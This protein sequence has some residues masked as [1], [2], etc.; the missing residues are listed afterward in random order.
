MG[1]AGGAATG[2]RTEAAAD[3]GGGKE[4]DEEEDGSADGETHAGRGSRPARTGRSGE[5]S[6]GSDTV[7][8]PTGPSGNPIWSTPPVQAQA[9]VVTTER[10]KAAGTA[11]R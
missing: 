8:S 5:A 1:G 4:A 11:A 9:S 3:E 7:G 2:A 6:T 10:T